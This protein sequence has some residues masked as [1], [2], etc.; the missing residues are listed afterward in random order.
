MSNIDLTYLL[1]FFLLERLFIHIRIKLMFHVK[2]MWK[3]VIDF[4]DKI[5]QH[6]WHMSITSAPCRNINLICL[7]VNSSGMW[8]LIERGVG[9]GVITAKCTTVG[10]G[11]QQLVVRHSWGCLTS[12]ASHYIIHNKIDR[13]IESWSNALFAFYIQYH[14]LVL[15]FTVFVWVTFY[16]RY[17]VD[18]DMNFSSNCYHGTTS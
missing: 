16:E 2:G 1:V 6:N 17:F 3:L 8:S 11:T 13:R 4:R 12:C 5:F 14:I 10:R 9:V 18:L 15:G 7:H